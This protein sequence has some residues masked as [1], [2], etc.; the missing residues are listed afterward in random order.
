[1]LKKE[2]MDIETPLGSKCITAWL[3]CTLNS[4]GPANLE[5]SSIFHINAA[6]LK[7]SAA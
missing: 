1:M 7:A 2:E 6:F 4:Q 3:S 5:V